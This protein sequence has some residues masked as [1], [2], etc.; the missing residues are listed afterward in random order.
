MCASNCFQGKFM[1]KISHKI[2]ISYFLEIPDK[3]QKLPTEKT[4]Y[5]NPVSAM[6]K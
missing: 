1:Q 2:S 6:K 5:R 3:G 4:L